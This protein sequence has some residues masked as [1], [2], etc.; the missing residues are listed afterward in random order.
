MKT[1]T[2]RQMRALRVAAETLLVARGVAPDADETIDTMEWLAQQ[3]AAN[4]ENFERWLRR[5]DSAFPFTQ[6]G[7]PPRMSNLT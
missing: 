2:N 6:L 1:K 7:I 3:W 5:F 4:P